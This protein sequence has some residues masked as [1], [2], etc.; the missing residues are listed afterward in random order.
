MAQIRDAATMRLTTVKRVIL[1]TETRARALDKSGRPEALA[2]VYETTLTALHLALGDDDPQPAWERVV[3]TLTDTH[4]RLIVDAL[5]AQPLDQ[6][7]RRL[8]AGRTRE[9]SG[10][11]E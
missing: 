3:A 11:V 5:D 8:A 1:D 6:M 2:P 7:R 10:M 9:L 4:R